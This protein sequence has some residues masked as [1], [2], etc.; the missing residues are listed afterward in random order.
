MKISRTAMST[1]LAL[2]MVIVPITVAQADPKPQP[3]PSV[4]Q[5][6]ETATTQH[7]TDPKKR[8][9]QLGRGWQTS[10]DRVWTTSGDADGF[11]IF[12]ADAATGYSWR[13]AATLAEPGLDVDQWVGNV[14]V[15]ESGKRAAA[16][17]APRMFTNKAPLAERGGFTAVVDLD[18]GAVTKL[19]VRASLAYFNPGC[20]TG[21]SAVLTQ[22]G[23]EQRP[24]TRLIPVNVAT[25]ELGE[26][27]ESPGQL[28]SA[29]PTAAGIIAADG[30]NL[31]NLTTAGARTVL[32]RANGVPFHV[33]PDADGGVVFMDR[34]VDEVRVHRVVR[35]GQGISDTTLA[36]GKVGELGMTSGAAGRVFLTGKADNLSVLPSSVAK[37]DVPRAAVPSTEGKTAIVDSRHRPSSPDPGSPEQV[38]LELK[39][40]GTG[41]QVRL[42]IDPAA[43]VTDLKGTGRA[44]NPAL[45]GAEGTMSTAGLNNPV[46]SERTCSIPRSDPHN[47]VTQPTSAQVEWAADRAVLGTLE[48]TTGAQQM[49]PSIPLIS[50]QKVP[51]QIL[52]GIMA[53]E[54]NLWQASRFAL[55]GVAAN[56]LIGNYYG[57]AIY[58]KDTGDDWNIRWDDADCG[59]G[60]TQVTDGMRM[61]GRTRPGEQALPANQQRAIAL[62]Y[63]TN[64]ARGL[65]I[66][67]GKWNETR[68]AGMVVNNGSPRKIENWFFA[69]W[70]YNSGFYPDKGDGSPWGLGWLNNPANPRYPGDRKAFLEFD[71]ADAKNPQR[72]P[73]PE[74]VMGWAAHSIDTSSGPGFAPAWW[75]TETDR[76]Q[77]KPPVDH[78]CTAANQC[79]PGEKIPPPPP[80]PGEDP[81]KPGPCDHRD[82]N[83][84]TDLKCWWHSASTWKPDCD[85]KCGNWNFTYDDENGPQPDGTNY[86]PQCQQTGLPAGALIID[87]INQPITPHAWTPPGR[88]CTRNWTQQGSFDLTFGTSSAKI[89]FHQIGAAFDNHFYFAHTHKYDAEASLSGVTGTW[90][91]S[92]PLNS[93]ARVLVHLPDHGA[94]TQQAAYKISLGDGR[95]KT[96]YLSQGTEENKWVSLGTYQFSGTPKVSLSTSTEDGF[97]VEDVAWDAIAFQPLPSKPK[98]IVAALGDSYSSGEGAGN[99]FRES[100]NNHGTTRWAACRRSKDS[101]SR[102]MT[103]PGVSG[104]TGSLADGRNPNVEL[105][106]VACSGA[107]SWEVDGNGVPWSWSE[108]ERYETGEGQFHEMSQT[109]SG[110]LDENTTLVTLSI[111]GN[112]A[113]FAAAVTECGDLLD[114]SRDNTFLPRFKQ[115]VDEVQPK[116]ARVLSKVR[117]KAPNAQVV[118]MGYP[119]L[120]SRTVKCG[121]SWYF[122]GSE[123]AVLAEVGRYLND[124]E[125]KTTAAAGVGF[126]FADPVGAFVGHAGCDSDE[127]IHKIRIGPN[128]EGDFHKGDKPSPFCLWDVL[129]GA[130]MSRESFHPN[131]GGTSGY[132]RV[133]EDKLRQIGYQGS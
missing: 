71:R 13:T 127:W 49:F 102:K 24:R 37:L 96:R 42:A 104:S 1:G 26:R 95:V 70:A 11:H 66:L 20:G 82:A 43:E 34:A 32:A 80:A 107:F 22:D 122:D 7:S 2:T 23:D 73:Y 93:W 15:T 57:L 5:V 111:G 31:V 106:F 63:K 97:G 67:Q 119:E 18:T 44:L 48:N 41:K 46:D 109:E 27:I 91:L 8:D 100:D 113:G 60:V 98:H 101:W 125:R 55:P 36:T 28:T 19:P 56:P 126:H 53:Q 124:E 112:D 77:V 121:G 120:L 78:F 105:G 132:A 3:P 54:S 84:N 69:V 114:C 130:C 25:G 52:L 38:E 40:L 16:V 88:R 87:D 94:H 58:N 110:V 115:K 92:S 108:P 45:A 128:G 62:D 10:T 118:V 133:M 39:V 117:A 81:E 74:K 35:N 99:Y 103:L 72:W 76:Q 21:E 30:A 6:T 83:G 75:L 85:N 86:P 9:E 90:T 50:G 17:Y 4:N 33:H 116:L 64:I 123:V 51:P 68:S 14:C 12:V 89:D 59:Y 131:G 79:K 61:A 29:V 47:Q 129:G 65:Q